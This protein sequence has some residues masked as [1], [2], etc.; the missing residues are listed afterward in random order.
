MG[1]VKYID[2]EDKKLIDNQHNFIMQLIGK[3]YNDLSYSCVGCV[4]DV[5]TQCLVEERFMISVDMIKDKT[6][7]C[8]KSTVRT[9]RML[10]ILRDIDR[11]KDPL[12]EINLTS[13]TCR[14]DYYED[15]LKLFRH[16][17]APEAMQ[18]LVLE[19]MF[20][21]SY[22]GNEDKI[23]QISHEIFDYIRYATTRSILIETEDDISKEEWAA[24]VSNDPRDYLTKKRALSQLKILENKKQLINFD[25]SQSL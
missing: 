13:L 8:D 1:L 12:H 15:I 2:L 7:E 9:A 19:Y 20:P 3:K 14:T 17:Q 16:R 24:S 5:I 21:E 11:L 25:N 6:N 18:E 23:A 22:R 10:S 4:V